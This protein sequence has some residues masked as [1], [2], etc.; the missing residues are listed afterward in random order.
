MSFMQEI[1]CHV[2]GSIRAGHYS[3]PTPPPLLIARWQTE[4][5]V[6][7]SLFSQKFKIGKYHISSPGRIIVIPESSIL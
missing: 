2:P 3:S 5:R 6:L 7:Q 4:D 1:A